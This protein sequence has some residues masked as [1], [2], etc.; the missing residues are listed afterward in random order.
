MEHGGKCRKGLLMLVMNMLKYHVPSSVMKYGKWMFNFMYHTCIILKMHY[1]INAM[2]WS[3]FVYMFILVERSK[4]FPC[5]DWCVV[6]FDVCL[7]Q[8]GP[9]LLGGKSR[10]TLALCL[11][12]LY[13]RDVL[14]IVRKDVSHLWLL[15][16]GVLG[17][18]YTP[19]LQFG[20]KNN[21][22]CH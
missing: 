20:A 2:M 12:G 6:W 9:N 1:M 8:S 19:E 13:R 5:M 10:M 11:T 4:M 21:G 16:T 15:H 14:M 7:N 3:F 18:L 22:L 17:K